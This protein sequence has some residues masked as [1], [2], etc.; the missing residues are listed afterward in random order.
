MAPVSRMVHG[1]TEPKFLNRSAKQSGVKQNKS[2]N[3]SETIPWIR[4]RY[5]RPGEIPDSFDFVMMSSFAID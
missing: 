5:L 4:N 2:P 3:T 1:L